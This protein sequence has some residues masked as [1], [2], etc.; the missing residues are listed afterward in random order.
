MFRVAIILLLCGC[1]P[2]IKSQ[3]SND[4]QPVNT[5]AE[6]DGLDEKHHRRE[7]KALIGLDPRRYEWCAAF[8]NSILELHD[9]PGSETVSEYPLLA[10]S[11]LKWGEPVE[12][13][14][15]G[16][17]VVFTRNN[18][19]WK[20]HVGFYIESA[21]VNGVPSYIVL[22]GNQDNMINHKAYPTSRL[23]GIRRIPLDSD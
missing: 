9:I 1:T 5:A 18:S 13:P 2:I 10:R 7:I 17:I 15:L 23:I 8:I 6:F 22:G 4:S 20:G 19:N 16:D 21:V 12:E 14:E 3:L 11:F